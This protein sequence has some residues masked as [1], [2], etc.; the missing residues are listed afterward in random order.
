MKN[1]K[2]RYELVLLLA[3]TCSGILHAA[4]RIRQLD[5]PR[6]ALL[7]QSVYWLIEV[8]HPV[9]ESYDLALQA[10]AG[11]QMELENTSYRRSRDDLVSLYRVRFTPQNLK[12]GGPPAAILTDLKGESVVI[13]GKSVEVSAISGNSL[14]VRD[15]VLPRFP[16]PRSNTTLIAAVGVIGALLAALLI[17]AWR[18]RLSLNPRN[19]LIR[20]LSQV[21]TRIGTARPPDPSWV[22]I[23]LRSDLL[24]GEMV[25]AAT[26]T[27]LADRAKQTKQ[28]EVLSTALQTLEEARYSG[29]VVSDGALVEQ[30][31]Q[32]A[33]EILENQ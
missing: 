30:S 15:P 3:L 2:T 1:T 4:P 32:A 31:V 28:H 17:F 9:W 24:W 13:R 21:R 10:P 6:N 23:L 5:P 18:R 12:I 16:V 7:G 26:V 22:C 25:N 11:A 33:L 20:Q 14:D 19:V 29:G 8:R 27:E